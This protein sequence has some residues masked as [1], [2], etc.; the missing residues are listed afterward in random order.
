[1]FCHCPIDERIQ[2]IRVS[3][4]VYDDLWFHIETW[5]FGNYQSL[6]LEDLH[7]SI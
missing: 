4:H 1:M 2:Q 7:L 6:R 3:L 5:T